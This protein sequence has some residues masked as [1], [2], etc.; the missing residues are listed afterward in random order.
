[1]ST[2]TCIYHDLCLRFRY[3]DPDTEELVFEVYHLEEHKRMRDSLGE[4][5]LIWTS[6]GLSP[7]RIQGAGTG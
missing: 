2:D 6:E 5:R 3:Q 7:S 1:M 4:L